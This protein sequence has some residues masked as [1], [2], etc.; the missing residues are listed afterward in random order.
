MKRWLAILLVSLLIVES[1][2]AAPFTWTQVAAPASITASSETRVYA[3]SKSATADWIMFRQTGVSAGTGKLFRRTSGGVTQISAGPNTWTN[4]LAVNYDATLDQIV[5]STER[6]FATSSPSGAPSWTTYDLGGS[7]AKWISDKPLRRLTSNTWMVP[8]SPRL[9]SSDSISLFYYNVGGGSGS[10]IQNYSPSNQGWVI[11]QVSNARISDTCAIVAGAYTSSTY[12]TFG[13][14]GSDARSFTT[15]APAGISATISTVLPGFAGLSRGFFTFSN[16]T[17][18]DLVSIT[19]AGSGT[20]VTFASLLVRPGVVMNLTGS[21]TAYLVRS[22]GRVYGSTDGTNFS[23]VDTATIP[24]LSIVGQTVLALYQNYSGRMGAIVSDGS[25][26]E[27]APNPPV[28]TISATPS[29][30]PLGT[31]TTVTWSVTDATSCTASGA[32]SGSKNATSGSEAVTI[33]AVNTNTLTLSCTGLG[34]SGNNSAVV[35]G[36]AVDAKVTAPP[37]GSALTNRLY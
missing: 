2:Q 18:T 15:D 12:P 21:N 5:T 31:T 28:V 20:V 35:T 13:L 29:L 9:S 17:S 22:D 19:C 25:L 36:L 34:G 3:S 32:W 37:Y 14:N 8:V 24:Q 4:Y 10:T 7:N 33:S 16:G 6:Q 1:A 26:Y 27:L 30:V 11:Q 23:L